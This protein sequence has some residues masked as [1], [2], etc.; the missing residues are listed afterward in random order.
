[1]DTNVAEENVSVIV[2]CPHSEVE[3]HPRV[4][5]IDGEREQKNRVEIKPKGDVQELCV[6]KVP[7]HITRRSERTA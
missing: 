5:T 1:M 6:L 3:I 2:M 7:Y 4:G